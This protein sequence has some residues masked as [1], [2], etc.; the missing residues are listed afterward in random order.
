MN[1]IKTGTWRVQLVEVNSKPAGE[2]EEFSL[3]ISTAQT[4]RLDPA[5]IV[6]QFQQAT[7]RSAILESRSQIFFAD[8]TTRGN[9]LTIKLSRPAFAEKIAIIAELETDVLEPSIVKSA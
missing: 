2:T 8:F 5:G 3:L 6:F 1:P 7:E 9:R 4:L